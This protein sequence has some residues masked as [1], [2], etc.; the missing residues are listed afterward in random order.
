MSSV[1]AAPSPLAG[2]RVKTKRAMGGHTGGAFAGRSHAH[3]SKLDEA[4]AVLAGV[5]LNH[6]P[7]TRWN[8]KPKALYICHMV[9]RILLTSFGKRCVASGDASV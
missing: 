4:R 7:V 2:G 9:R 6:V 3:V 1:L 8:F 5:V